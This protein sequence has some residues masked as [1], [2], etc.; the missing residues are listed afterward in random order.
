MATLSSPTCHVAGRELEQQAAG[1][2][3]WWSEDMEAYDE[4]AQ[5]GGQQDVGPLAR[6][7]VLSKQQHTYTRGGGSG[8]CSDRMRGSRMGECTA[9][10]WLCRFFAVL[11]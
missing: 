3:G 7:S 1:M 5:H 6:A 2:K 8:P 10:R 9:K 4:Q 11:C